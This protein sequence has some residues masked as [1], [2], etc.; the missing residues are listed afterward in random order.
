MLIIT[1]PRKYETKNYNSNCSCGSGYSS[2]NNIF[3]DKRFT[4]GEKSS[5]RN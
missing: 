1:M 4:A 5:K 2:Y 3:C